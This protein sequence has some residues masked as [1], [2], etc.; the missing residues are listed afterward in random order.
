MTDTRQALADAFKVIHPEPSREW[1]TWDNAR[2][3]EQ[4]EEDKASFMRWNDWRVGKQARFRRFLDAEAWTDAAMCLV[5]PLI[6]AGW[7]GELG[8]LGTVNLR[9]PTDRRKDVSAVNHM[10]P[11]LALAQACLKARENADG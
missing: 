7:T 9:H 10:E 6:E 3:A 5:Q 11:A 1:E 4:R 2:F 8:L